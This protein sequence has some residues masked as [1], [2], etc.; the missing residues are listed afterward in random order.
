MTPLS[1]EL[2]R[3]EVV[4]SFKRKMS[5]QDVARNVSPFADQVST[6]KDA[7]AAYDLPDIHAE[8]RE[9]IEQTLRAVGRGECKS[10]IILLA[11]AAG[12]GKTHLLRTFDTRAPT[13][14]PGH[15]YVGGSN[16][17][18][19][20]EFQ[21]RLLD[22]VIEALTFPSPSEE[23]LLLKRV[24]AIGFRAIDNLL[25]SPV[26]WRDCLARC[27]RGWLGWLLHRLRA[28]SHD[29]LRKLAE[30]RDPSLFAL[31][32]FARFSEYVC[33]RFLA[34][35]SNLTHRFAL[36]VLLLAPNGICGPNC[37]E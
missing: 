28:P 18:A 9:R 25:E 3:L 21:P 17:W 24:Q 4:R 1:P 31:L 35:R 32:D 33:D 7:V 6:T 14:A 10:Q 26:A 36:R 11:G 13:S 8:V 37:K 34:D 23:N 22:W 29:S 5:H 19:I 15:V 30:A 12:A 2:Q 16:Q 27:G 20:N